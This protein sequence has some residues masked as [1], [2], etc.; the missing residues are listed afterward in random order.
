LTITISISR[1]QRGASCCDPRAFFFDNARQSYQPDRR[2]VDHLDVSTRPV[3]VAVAMGNAFDD[4]RRIFSRKAL[5]A[6]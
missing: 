2:G 4:K 6:R 3:D 1:E 5:P